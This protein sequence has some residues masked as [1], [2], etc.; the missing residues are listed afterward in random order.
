MR[1]LFTVADVR[2]EEMSEDALRWSVRMG[3]Y[4]RVV[5][6]VYAEGPEPPSALDRERAKVVAADGVA[7]GG[8]AGVLHGLDAAEL[9]GR[10]LRR[11]SLPPNRIVSI[12]SLR[13][14][15][16]VQTVLDLA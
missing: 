1:R 10:P 5:R 9:D 14:T 12:G 7:C 8:L 6:G 11:R 4:R 13:C 2:F 16:G 3:A 15:N